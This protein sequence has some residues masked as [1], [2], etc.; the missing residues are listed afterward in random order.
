MLTVSVVVP[1]WNEEERIADC[2]LNATTQSVAPLEVLVVDNKSTDRTAQI[3]SDFIDAHPDTPVKLLHQDK[4]Q[5]LIPTRNYGLDRAKGQV[6]GRVDADCMLRPNWVEVVGNLFDRDPQAMGATGPVAYYDMPA[7]ELGLKGDN[8]VRKSVYRA[9]DGRYLLFGSNMAL[10][11]S[12]WKAIRGEV[13]RDKADIM[14]EDVDIS[15]HLID[16]DFKTVYCRNMNAGISAR[17]MDTSFPSFRRYMQRFKNTFDAHP[18]HTREQKPERTLYAIYPVLRAFYPVYQK[19]L[20]SADIN[21][22]ER[23][24]IKEQ[25]ELFHQREQEMC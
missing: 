2:I 19:Y 18:Q 14:H 10:R 9:D 4:E 13:C 3:V 1:A 16:H 5:G 23:V 25:M 20:E 12:A 22:A 11:A 24:W 15:L 6:L 21:P 7:K 17:R 8:K